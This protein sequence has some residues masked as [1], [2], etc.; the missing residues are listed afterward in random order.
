METMIRGLLREV[1][2]LFNGDIDAN[3]DLI[4]R[5]EDLKA[6]E[7]EL[8]DL[9]KSFGD[10][11]ATD[12]EIEAFNRLS[13]AVRDLRAGSNNT[14]MVTLV[15][16]GEEGNVKAMK[17]LSIGNGQDWGIRNESEDFFE[18]GLFKKRA[19]GEFGIQVAITDTDRVNPFWLF[20]RRV[21]SGVF[22]SIVKPA[23]NDIG[24]V[25][26]STAA[27]EFTSDIQGKIK[28]KPGDKITIVAVSSVAKFVV[29]DK[30]ALILTNAGE[31][32][33]FSKGELT[34]ALSI[35]GLIQT[36]KGTAG[37]KVYSKPGSPNGKIVIRMESEP[38]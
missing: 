30:G 27:F 18:T 9:L 20:L 16:P 3:N 8:N 36:R 37:K 14:L 26:V 15:H 11:D 12:N 25:F 31:D 38:L 28:G 13:D 2:V 7:K 24:N 33:S 22:S 4:E 1:H 32:I 10:E 19:V 17:S 21:F 23:I 6:K 34:L 35:P 5:A 29:G